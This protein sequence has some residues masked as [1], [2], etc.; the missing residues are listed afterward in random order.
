MGNKTLFEQIKT[1]CAW[2]S[3]SFYHF[4][5]PLNHENYH[6][7]KLHRAGESHL[8]FDLKR[9]WNLQVCYVRFVLELKNKATKRL[10][11]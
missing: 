6:Q 11:G 10:I 7:I 1:V 4:Q 2:S 9:A 5:L 3:S 8:I